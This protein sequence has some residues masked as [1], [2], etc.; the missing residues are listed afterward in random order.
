MLDLKLTKYLAVL[1]LCSVTAF[2]G[3]SDKQKKKQTTHRQRV[4]VENQQEATRELKRIAGADEELRVHYKITRMIVSDVTDK[5]L[6]KY[7]PSF[8]NVQL[9]AIQNGSG[10]NY[11]PNYKAQDDSADPEGRVEERTS[12]TQ[13]SSLAKETNIQPGAIS[14]WADEIINVG[15]KVWSIIE[16]GRP[17][18]SQKIESANALPKG[19]EEWT[20]LQGWSAPVSRVYSIVYENGFGITMIDLT[21]RVT[22]NYGG[23]Y[24]GRGKYIANASVQIENL[25]IGFGGIKYDVQVDVPAVF[26]Q[27]TTEDPIAGMQLNIK[28]VA[29]TIFSRNENTDSFFLNGLGVLEKF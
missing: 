5:F 3:H 2:A 10:Q 6:N 13:K 4:M 21:F 12:K 24:R 20:D 15:T 8:D 1:C 25:R 29:D 17:V 9:S 7:S 11:S 28:R 26:N 14:E 16:A 22:F 18:S 19:V 27:G 23:N